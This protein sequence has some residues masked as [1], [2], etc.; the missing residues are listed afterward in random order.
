MESSMRAVGAVILE[1]TN[2]AIVNRVVKISMEFAAKEAAAKR[3][4][5]AE[6]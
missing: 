5:A 1:Q 3:L 2:A 6:R 4:M